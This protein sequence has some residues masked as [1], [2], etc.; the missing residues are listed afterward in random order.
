MLARTMHRT[1]SR[2]INN[3]E[4]AALDL[5]DA[6]RGSLV[7][8]DILASWNLEPWCVARLEWDGHFPQVQFFFRG[9]PDEEW[10]SAVERAED[11]LYENGYALNCVGNWAEELSFMYAHNLP[12]RGQTSQ[13][14]YLQANGFLGAIRG[15]SA[16]PPPPP[17]NPPPPPVD[18]EEG[19]MAP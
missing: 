14:V 3:R 12:A 17:A 9:I 1:H 2:E 4:Q 6:S 11:Y 13:R 16:P 18:E 19:D 10:E 8:G 5:A 7:V 15:P